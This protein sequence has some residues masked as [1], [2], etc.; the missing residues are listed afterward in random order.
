VRRLERGAVRAGVPEL[1]MALE[2]L[3]SRRGDASGCRL[4]EL[5]LVLARRLTC[6][7]EGVGVV[8]DDD[9]SGLVVCV[10]LMR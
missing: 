3:P 7:V 9:I 5:K 1:T 6:V 8:R 4:G 2:S 10:V